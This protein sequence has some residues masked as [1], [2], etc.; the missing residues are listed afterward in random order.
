MSPEDYARRRQVMLSVLYR[1]QIGE[2]VPRP[3][4]PPLMI[5]IPRVSLDRQMQAA[6]AMRT[7][8]DRLEGMMERLCALTAD[9]AAAES[10]DAYLHKRSYFY[11]LKAKI[12]GFCDRVGKP[13]PFIGCPPNN[14]WTVPRNDYRRVQVQENGT[15]A[16]VV[17]G[18]ADPGKV[19]M[20]GPSGPD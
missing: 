1:M 14:P 7:P 15:L 2:K 6:L 9:M 5:S 10:Q 12:W 16:L 13:R 17:E 19:S 4:L 20:R 18:A 11:S 8:D 3:P